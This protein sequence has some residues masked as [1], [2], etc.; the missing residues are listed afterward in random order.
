[1]AQF[2]E[3]VRVEFPYL[4][5]VAGS[6]PRFI[7]IGSVGELKQFKSYLEMFQCIN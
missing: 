3:L 2:G 6:Y 1:V 5:M 4:P 7:N